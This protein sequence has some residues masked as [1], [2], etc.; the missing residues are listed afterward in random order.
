MGHKSLLLGISILLVYCSFA[1]LLSAQ[2]YT[3]SVICK[4]S[5]KPVEYANIGVINKETGTVSDNQGK[6][7]IDLTKAGDSDTLMISC[8]GYQPYKTTVAKFKSGQ[9][10]IVL[11]EQKIFALNEVVVRPINYKRK[12]LGYRVNS[13]NIQTGFNDNSL[14]YECGVM[15]KTR[16]P[17]L[18]ETLYLDIATCKYDT[19]FYR[20]NVYKKTGEAEFENILTKPIFINLT[21]NHLSR[22]T[23]IDLK[24]YNITIDEDFL[25]TIEHIRN[26]GHNGLFFRCR[27]PGK[28]WGRKTSQGSWFS[29]PLGLGISMDVLQYDDK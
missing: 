29:V 25:V 12:K 9:G 18:L 24:P 2:Q 21:R 4:N 16:K 27:F 22:R 11:L 17:V 28:T 15:M 3:G 13:P 7:S 10:K 5:G 23:S 19:V 6:Y 8:I 1:Q 20:I 26:L 14:G